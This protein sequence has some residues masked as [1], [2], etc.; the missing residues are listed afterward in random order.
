MPI[1]FIDLKAQFAVLEP[2]I[3]ARMDAVLAHGKFIMGPEVAELETALAAFA[4]T[5]HAVSCASGTD[6]LLMPLLAW[7]VGPGDVVF[8]TPFTFI[9]T[10][11]VIALL[12]ATPVFVDIDPRTYNIDPARLTQAIHAVRAQ[13]PTLH[14]LPVA[15]MAYKLRPKA[16][17]P[18]DLFGLPADYDAIA[19]VAREHGL[20]VLEDAAQGFGGVYKGKKAGA[21]GTAGATSFFPAKPLGCFGD[22]GAVLTDDDE[23]A[24][25]LRSI[26]VHGKGG[27]KYDNVRVGLNCRLDTLQAAILLAKLPAFPGELDA[28]DAAAARYAAGLTGLPGLTLPVV[29]EGCRCAWAQY[30]LRLSRRDAVAAAL[31]EAGVPSMV[32]YPKPLHTQTAFAGLG[33]APGDFPESLAA[34]EQVLSL[35][36]HPYLTADVQD[37]IVAAVKTAVRHS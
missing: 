35:P 30:T 34:S 13:D 21:L 28:R 22:G 15:A 8:T 12:G 14:P 7:G 36:M 29:P 10:A 23:L 26:R 4:G 27:H 24:E 25:T 32:Y 17:I 31:R 16:V 19:A 37:G 9:A 5:R 3:R 20:V 6:A 1:P 18:V 2:E 33:H 11:E